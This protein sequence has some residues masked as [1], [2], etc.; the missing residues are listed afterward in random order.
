MK[1]QDEKKPDRFLRMPEVEKLTGM[2]KSTIYAHAR[3]G[4]F[5]NPKQIGSRSI[6]FLESDVQAWIAARINGK[7]PSI[8]SNFAPKKV[9]E[10]PKGDALGNRK[11]LLKRYVNY[12]IT[13][14]DDYW[15]CLA[16]TFEDALIMGGATPNV[17][18]TLLDLFRETKAF[19]LQ[20]FS[21]PS[22]LS[23]TVGWPTD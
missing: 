18:Y 15:L 22:G 23:I 9:D 14:L 12:D 7:K 11:K 8:P 21:T 5:P 6:G 13:T 2:K 19:A 10:T 16:S 3:E 1:K 4:S 17:D 20:A